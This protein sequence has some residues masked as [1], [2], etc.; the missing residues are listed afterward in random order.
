SQYQPFG[1]GRITHS[2]LWQEGSHLY[3]EQTLESPTGDA[4]MRTYLV[5][6]DRLSLVAINGDEA[7]LTKIE[8]APN[9]PNLHDL[10]ATELL[11]HLSLLPL[12]QDLAAR[13]LVQA[14]PAVVLT[15]SSRLADGAARRVWLKTDLP[16][17]RGVINAN[18]GQPL[19][20][21]LLLAGLLPID[22]K[23]N[24]AVYFYSHE[25]KSLYFQPKLDAF[26][27]PVSLP[28]LAS[29][30]PDGDQLYGLTERGTLH[31]MDTQGGAHLAAVNGNWI[32]AN[33]ADLPATLARVVSASGSSL[34]GVALLGLTDLDGKAVSSWYD[35]ALQRVIQVGNLLDGR[36]LGYLGVSSDEGYA[37]MVDQ[38]A[39][40][41]YRQP[42]VKGG[43]NPAISD[44]LV[45][46][47]T[48]Q[49]PEEVLTL[50]DGVRSVQ[51][52]G[53]QIRIETGGL[54]LMLPMSAAPGEQATLIGVTQAWVDRQG[55]ALDSEF[56]RLDRD[57]RLAPA[58]R[59]GENSASWYLTRES[60]RLE[61]MGMAGGNVFDYLGREAGGVTRYVYD[62]TKQKLFGL[63]SA[64]RKVA[65]P[66][67]GFSWVHLGD[68]VLTLIATL[69]QNASLMPPRLAEAS[70]VLMSA[71]GN[72]PTY[73]V[74]GAE[75]DHYRRIVVEDQSV[76][77][78]VKL[79]QSRVE[80]L[81]VQRLDGRLALY[82]RRHAGV[83]LLSH[84]GAVGD[85]GLRIKIEDHLIPLASLSAAVMPGRMVALGALLE[86]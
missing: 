38:E 61:G 25:T 14:E 16:V 43:D 65:T 51:R 32:K 81:M 77:A 75:L 48:V 45:V 22:Q 49:V 57:Y 5:E 12:S 82:D 11:G 19:P 76:G 68:G 36:R 17:R 56:G 7:L 63:D 37:W 29:V 58:V 13:R 41:L 60:R 84:V 40:I 4:V 1:E 9:Q 80:D 15:V 26:A 21:D 8:R 46:S 83:L 52:I 59:L 24:H 10:A 64:N 30:L 27:R 72:R 47:D 74:G 39:A 70:T 34:D 35:A 62:R 73:V 71:H 31:Q 79:P 67:G 86:K 6:E 54:I 20:S 18:L 50:A 23:G 2:R 69:G 53:D 66:L 55:V 3:W 28:G 78:Q 33:L 44:M 42:I 85:D